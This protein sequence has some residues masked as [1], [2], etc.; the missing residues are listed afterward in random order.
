MISQMEQNKTEL[1]FK[2]TFSIMFVGSVTLPLKNENYI[3]GAR[4]ATQT[5]F[6]FFE[7]SGKMIHIRVINLPKHS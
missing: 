1:I 5:N 2:V 6:F 7:S 4:K 3:K